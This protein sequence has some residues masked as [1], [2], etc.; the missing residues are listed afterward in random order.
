MV[1]PYTEQTA[2]RTAHT[3]TGSTREH[4]RMGDGEYSLRTLDRNI[5]RSPCAE[6]ESTM[7]LETVTV[8]PC[9]PESL[10]AHARSSAI[11]HAQRMFGNADEVAKV[12]RSLDVHAPALGLWMFPKLY[13]CRYGEAVLALQLQ[14]RE[15]DLICEHGDGTAAAAAAGT[16]PGPVEPRSRRFALQPGQSAGG[17]LQALTTDVLYVNIRDLEEDDADEFQR[18]HVACEAAQEATSA[19]ADTTQSCVTR[20]REVMQ[21]LGLFLAGF[22]ACLVWLGGA[23]TGTGTCAASI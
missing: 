21:V 6:W 16:G 3:A 23:G 20:T 7:P 19:A 22:L 10:Q 5:K 1:F 4:V 15:L 11:L 12:L 13:I 9:G 14:V 17:V 8:H 18:L 2:D